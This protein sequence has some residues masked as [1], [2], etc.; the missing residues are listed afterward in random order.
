MKP[1]EKKGG[2]DWSKSRRFSQVAFILCAI[3]IGQF[4]DRVIGG[5]LFLIHKYGFARVRAEHLEMVRMPKSGPWLVSNG[6]TV[7]GAGIGWWLVVTVITFGLIGV[8]YLGVFR[9]LPAE[10]RK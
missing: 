4:C 2:F 6:D 7:P 3:P 1:P 10:P 9:L 8:V 5:Y